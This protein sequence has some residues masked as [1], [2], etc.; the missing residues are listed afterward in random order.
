MFG[1]AAE[2]V[3]HEAGIGR[4]LRALRAHRGEVFPDR[5]EKLL[6]EIA[7]T[8]AAGPEFPGHGRCVIG[9]GEKFVELVD[10]IAFGILRR[11]DRCRVGDDAHDFF[12]HRLLVGENFDRVVVALAHFRAVRPGHGRG[13]LADA[14]F[15][16]L[17]NIAVGLVHFHRDV[18]GHL[19]VLFLVLADRDNVA[20]VDEDVRRHE[21]RVGEERVRRRD[22]ARD[23][24]FVGVTTLEQAHG[25]HRAQNPSKQ[26]HLRDIRLAE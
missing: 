25:S 8:G 15:R 5:S 19:E 14:R 21:H 24:V 26:R 6:F 20:V 22:S 12:L 7:V 16:E 23:F 1:A 2:D 18:A 17:E 10:R 9:G 4:D 11:L 3:I 13:I